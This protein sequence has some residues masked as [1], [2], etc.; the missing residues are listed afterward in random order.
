VKQKVLVTRATFDEVVER[1]R[2]RFEVEDNQ[3]DDTPWSA[4]E[5]RRRMSDKDGVLSTGSDRMDA[6]VLGSAP[7]LKAVCNVA[8]GY[9]NI[10]LAAC[11]ERGILA[12]NT[13]RVL[14]DT[15][16]DMAWAL[17]MAAARRVT[18]AERW[19]RSGHWKGWKNDQFLGVDVHHATLGIV[20]MG[21]IG[22]AIARRAKGF[23]M[24]VLYHNRRRVPKS[25]EKALGAKYVTLERL[26]GQ[27]DF[28]SLNM[29][30]SPESRH[31]I[32]A[33][34][35]A[36]M[37]PTAVIVNTARGGIIDDAALIAALGERRIAAAG[38]DVFEGEPD[39][40][41][42]FLGLDNVALVPHIGSA[43]RATRTAMAT[44]AIRNL[45]AALSGKRPPNLL[46][47]EAWP[48]RRR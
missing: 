39:F 36:L 4:E 19:L 21:R 9:N 28:V 34:Q 20:G 35:L 22:Q 46:N 27:S 45:T 40:N 30:Y 42:G 43:T 3:K 24:R 32:G 11:S 29:P 25:V 44:L 17:L 38:I 33:E 14:D 18:E 47:P 1:L 5:L 12:T 6:A 15:T 41:P 16:A 26:L 23:S 37:K 2:E 7:R 13:P 10:D 31:L 48:Q 8:V